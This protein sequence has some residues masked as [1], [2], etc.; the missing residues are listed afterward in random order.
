MQGEYLGSWRKGSHTCGTFRWADGTVYEGNFLDGQPH[1]QGKIMWPEGSA[2]GSHE[3]GR[4]FCQ[5][6]TTATGA[7]GTCTARALTLAASDSLRT[8]VPRGR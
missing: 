6:S 4:V 3:M 2:A 5:R 8:T 1:G 7:S